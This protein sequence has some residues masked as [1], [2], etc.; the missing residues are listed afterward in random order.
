MT[1][2]LDLPIV[3]AVAALL[4]WLVYGRRMLS[5]NKYKQPPPL[6]QR[7][8]SGLAHSPEIHG[9]EVP[10]TYMR[11]AKEYGTAPFVCREVRI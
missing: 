5:R 1:Q 3:V 11:W 7:F 9:S 4:V 2:R 6:P 10:R 8:F